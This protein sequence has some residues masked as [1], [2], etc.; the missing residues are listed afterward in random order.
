M[1]LLCTSTR[2]SFENGLGDYWKK[3]HVP[4]M[5]RCKLENQ[6]VGGPKPISLFELSSAFVILGI[7]L[8]L[9]ILVY[10]VE[11]II[12]VYKERGFKQ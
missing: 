9:G 7:G 5:D 8:S 4:S 11:K 2:R 3:K 6:D 10:L 12:S 1:L